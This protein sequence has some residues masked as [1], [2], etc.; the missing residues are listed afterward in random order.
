[1]RNKIFIIG[2]GFDLAHG[3]KTKYSDF[4]LWYVKEVYDKVSY[5]RH[6]DDKLIKI[7]RDDYSRRVKLV[8]I[9]SVKD[10]FQYIKINK[11]ELSF[12]YDFFKELINLFSDSNWVDIEY[13]Y[14]KSI[15][16]FYR[17]LEKG[18]V[19]E[20]PRITDLLI[21][22]NE[23]FEILKNNLIKYLK[24]I[25]ISHEIVNDDINSHFKSNIKK[26]KLKTDKILILNFNYTNTV[27][28]YVKSNPINGVSIVN[29]HGTIESVENPIIF[30]YGDEMDIYYKKIE[31]LNTYEFLKNFKS[32]GYFR[33]NNH[34]RV[35]SFLYSDSFEV[36]IMGH[37][38]G[39][40]DRVLLN[41]IFEHDNCKSIKIFYH[42]KGNNKNDYFEKTIEISR[43][44]QSKLKGVMRDK[45]ISFKECVPL[46]KF[47]V[48]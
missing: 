37:S 17:S 15:L 5:E 46:V 40:S 35:S 21:R 30:G 6:Y 9:S 18:S 12:K 25:E 7:S 2:N 13:Y 48:N 1:M 34:Q 3:L 41:K 36:F 10:F 14:Y 29:I 47:K 8:N 16:K 26:L 44:F 42:D 28:L 33:T 38:C 20:N 45:V 24:T 4:I 31:R 43:H 11:F 32:F 39:L 22:L 27:D 23:C 19:D